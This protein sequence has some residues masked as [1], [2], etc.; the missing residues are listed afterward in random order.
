MT[1]SHDE[2]RVMLISAA[3][4][5]A[6]GVTSPRSAFLGLTFAILYYLG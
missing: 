3:V 6:I 4:F 1:L 5:S 2:L